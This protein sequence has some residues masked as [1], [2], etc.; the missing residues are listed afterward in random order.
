MAD[1]ILSGDRSGEHSPPH[2]A[3]GGNP[4]RDWAPPSN[5]AGGN[6]DS[7]GIATLSARPD[8]TP[9]PRSRKS[10]CFQTLRRNKLLVA[11]SGVL[12]GLLGYAIVLPQVRVY[13]A[14]TTIE[15]AGI[16]ESFLNI[17]QSEPVSAPGTG[18]DATDIQTQITILKSDSLRDRV[19]AKLGTPAPEPATLWSRL[20]LTRPN[21]SGSPEAAAGMAAESENIRPI[22]NT[23]VIEITVDST[24]PGVAATF[25]NTLVNEFIE[26]NIETR[27]QSSM[28][29]GEWLSHQLDEM[30]A[31]IEDSEGRLQAY[32][33]SAGLVFTSDKSSLGEQQL[34][35][36]QQAR[37]T[38]ETER[39]AKQS[40]FEMLQPGAARPP[41]AAE[42]LTDDGLHGYQDKIAD[43]QRMIAELSV[44]YTPE[45]AKTKSLQAQLD[46][47]QKSYRAARMAL[48][49]KIG[50]QY[51][52]ALRKER[53]LEAS[54]LAQTGQVV[55]EQEKTTKYNLLKAEAESD[56]QLYDSLQQQLKQASVASAMKASNIR[57]V[58]AAAVP[59]APYKPNIPR[60]VIVGTLLGLVG[61]VG[62]ALLRERS[63]QTIREVG[64]V[65]DVLGVPELGLIPNAR[66]AL[67]RAEQ[68][69]MVKNAQLDLPSGSRPHA[70][71]DLITWRSSR[72]IV[73]DS[74]RS[75][76]TSMLFASFSAQRCR[77]FV[78]TSPSAGE[79]KSTVVSNLAVAIAEMGDRVL[80]IDGDLRNPR[81]Q[82]IFSLEPQPGL[83]TLLKEAPAGSETPRL[84]QCVRPTVIP[85][86]FVLPAGLPTSF[87]SSLLS[88][89]RLRETLEKLSTQFDK[90]LIDTPPMLTIP[91]ARILAKH[92]DAVV[93]VVRAGKT[94]RDAAVAAYERL[95]GDGTELVGAIMNDWDPAASAGGYY[96]YGYKY[97]AYYQGR[98]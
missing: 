30:R 29:T 47:V 93:L 63:N 78:I 58:D 41:A 53:L 89:V 19:L 79:G 45:H 34:R 31:K 56:R 95:L 55:S 37:S 86:L 61:A 48:A 88:S 94:T 92:V 21:G 4:T 73:A 85:N 18:T 72:S 70:E 64:E 5:G 35:E 43:L 36:L 74:F 67:S 32:A 65:A 69:L 82:R 76:V 33:K 84:D 54:Y 40:R 1:V 12:G 13:Q 57:V 10:R 9:A 62:I 44:I 6:R 39:I 96:G 28:R 71:I 8:G 15:V 98:E 59:S 50:D 90:I 51:Q 27:W 11:G 2:G 46:A 22:P 91:D 66:L 23:R 80:L 87:S 7:P 14:R 49:G 26:Q 25:A 17:R 16:N 60:S 77:R 81:L 3:A 24:R 68:K 20:G 38:A 83:S 75:A 52:E 42:N 97:D